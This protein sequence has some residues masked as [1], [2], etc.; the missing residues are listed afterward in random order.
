MKHL[1]I[2]LLTMALVLAS[3]LSETQAAETKRNP[4]TITRA[5]AEMAVNTPG[6]QIPPQAIEAAKRAVLDVVG[7]MMAGHDSSGV[8]E[9]TDQMVEWSGKPEATVWVHGHR[10]PAP[11]A[12]FANS[13]ATHALDLD[14]VHIPSTTHI[15]SVIVPTALAVGEAQ[16]ATGRQVLEAIVMGI[17][18]SGRLGRERKA[19]RQHDGFLPTSTMGGFG[20]AAATAR[21]KGLTVEQATDAMGIFYAHASGNRQALYDHTLAK[22]IQPAIAARAGIV[23]GYLAERGI[24][25]P[26]RVLEGA[27]GLF[28]LYGAGK[29]PLPDAAKLTAPREL[30][31]V[32]QLSFKR[33]ACC[34][35]SHPLLDATLELVTEHNLTVSDIQDVELF[36]VGVNSGVVGVPWRPGDN[37]HV[38]AQFCAPYEVATTIKNRRLGPTEIEN[39]RIAAD[40]EVDALARHIKLRPHSQFG[41]KYPGGQ[42]VRI[43]TTDGRTL[44][45]SGTPEVTFAPER[46]GPELLLAK[47]GDNAA[48]SKLCTAEQAEEIAVAVMTLDRC[49]DVRSFVADHLVFASARSKEKPARPGTGFKES[50]SDSYRRRVPE[51][52]LVTGGKAPWVLF[53]TYKSQLTDRI[54]AAYEPTPEFWLDSAWAVMLMKT[55]VIPRANHGIVA[56]AI[57]ELW[58]KRPTGKFY[59]HKGVQAYVE[60]KY[61][62]NVAG[63]LMIARTNPPQRQQ[64]A[65]RRKLLKMLCL[66]RT[67]QR[68]LLETADQHKHAVMPG[69]THIRHAQ[70]TTLGH[71][72]LSV[73]DPI[74]RSVNSLEDGYHAMSLNELGCG[75]LA[76]TSWPIDRELVSTYLACEGLIENTNDAVSYTDGYVQVT[77]AATNIMAVMSRMA[78]EM[79]QWSTLEYDMIDFEIGAGS[80]MMPNKRSNQGILEKT[81][82]GASVTLGALMEVA[83]MGTKL[84]QGDTNPLAYRL[85]NG[86]LRALDTIDECI[87]PYL[88]KL[89]TMIVHEDKMLALARHGYSCST[90]LANVL[91]RT[92]GL[93]YRTAH[94]VVNHFVVESAKQDIPSSEADINLLQQAAQSVV[95]KE[96]KITETELRQALDPVHFVNATKSQGGVSPEEVTRMIADRAKKLDAARGRNLQRIDRLHNARKRMLADLKAIYDATGPHQPET[97]ARTVD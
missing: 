41:D 96:L 80:F 71:Y 43:T 40:K 23:A 81:A 65:V 51:A 67:F 88:Y 60:N 18:V 44:V 70:P 72:L 79:E 62:I 42:T 58:E 97:Q 54:D 78:L 22:R 11:A 55:E 94:D 8:A 53:R 15:T 5:L 64:M 26:H 21:L 50:I 24:D 38:S 47:F 77:A 92:N 91:V 29:G 2:P 3:A 36:G 61:G 49:M 93:D 82:E 33:Y 19:R 57:L 12:A 37:P 84:P 7:C 52:A 35:G 9:V 39:H 89:P 75:A 31:E 4:G 68:I 95:A 16:G 69:Y 34:G 48:F 13:V 28:K 30:F 27:A 85:K 1:V 56:G 83:S 46:V 17:E 6:D 66:M 20:A 90:E 25:G 63:D 73:Y 14:D 87:E 32:Q 59:G 10:L 86:T 45:R 76:G 74:D